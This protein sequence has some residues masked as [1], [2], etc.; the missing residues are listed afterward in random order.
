MVSL[1]YQG[2]SQ[3]SEYVVKQKRQQSLK[4]EL[5]QGPTPALGCSPQA[6]S[7]LRVPQEYL[8]LPSQVCPGFAPH[9]CLRL[10]LLSVRI[11][12]LLLMLIFLE[13]LQNTT[14][15]GKLNL[16]LAKNKCKST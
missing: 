12:D 14:P 16:S 5:E 2:H 15:T 9:V 7:L 1:S 13:E 3:A 8:H 10:V 11:L 4:V 6:C